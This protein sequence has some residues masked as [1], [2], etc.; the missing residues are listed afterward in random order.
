MSVTITQNQYVTLNTT[1]H[2]AGGAD[3]SGV[4]SLT[5]S[6]NDGGQIV[7]LQNESNASCDVYAA[8]VGTAIVTAT[9]QNTGIA[10]SFT[11]IVT[12]GVLST[13]TLA[14]SAAKSK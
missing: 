1:C 4:V 11:V 12:N 5:W 9:D 13:L 2:D 14:A 10:M 3:C 8:G 6:Q 7:S